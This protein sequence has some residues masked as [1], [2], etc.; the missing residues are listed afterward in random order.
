LVSLSNSIEFVLAVDFV[1][2]TA[3]RARQYSSNEI[4]FQRNLI[5]EAD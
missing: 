4:K 5:G 3:S 1:T 2:G